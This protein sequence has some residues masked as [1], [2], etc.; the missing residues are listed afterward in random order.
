MLNRRMFSAALGAGALAP[1]A[2]AQSGWPDRPVKIVVPFGPG[3]LADVT[4]R[5]VGEK[6]GQKLGQQF[7]IDNRPGAGGATAAVVALNAPADGYTLALLT[8]GTAVSKAFMSN[9]GF[10]P[11][12]DFVPVS[13]LGYFDFLIVTSVD[14]PYK[15]LGELVAAAKAKPG[16]LNAGTINIGSTQHLSAVL[17]NSLAGIDVNLIPYK[18]TPDAITAVIRKDVDFIIDGFSATGKLIA[19]GRLRALASSGAAR[20]PATPDVPT[21]IEQGIAGYDVTS[22]NAIFAKKG[23]PEAVIGK[24]NAEIQNVLAEP[25]VKARLAALGIE[26]KGST[27]A[28]IGGKLAADIARWNGVIDSAKIARQ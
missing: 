3:G 27:P 25:D 5:V 23:T 18:T 2:F 10:D 1:A 9:L 6:L 4:S 16:G 14:H 11:S 12:A 24:L 28:E 15:T 17:L 7:L 22:W 13:T 19:D 20:S 26:A 8:N 21:A